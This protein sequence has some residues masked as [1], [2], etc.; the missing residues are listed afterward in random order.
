M[1]LTINAAGKM[2]PRIY[3]GVPQTDEERRDFHFSAWKRLYQDK[4]VLAP[5]KYE[6][7]IMSHIYGMP[8]RSTI[9]SIHSLEQHRGAKV[10]DVRFSV[11]STEKPLLESHNIESK[12]G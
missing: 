9:A 3:R 2:W 1:T 11:G 4:I 8:E 5:G 12:F 10:R 6:V 7:A